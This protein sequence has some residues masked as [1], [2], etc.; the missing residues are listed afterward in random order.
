MIHPTRTNLLLLK[1]KSRSVT[2]STGILKARRQ[3]LIRELLNATVPFLKSREEIRRL[4]G[5][6]LDELAISLGREGRG[7][8]DS[9]AVTTER[10]FTVDIIERRIWGLNYRDV[11]SA[12]SPVRNPQERGYDYS[13]T[14]LHLEECIYLFEKLVESMIG[15]AAFESKIKVIS[16]EIKKSTRRIRILEEKVLPEIKH[17]I[18]AISQYIS[19]RER[20]AHYRL[21]KFKEIVSE[22]EQKHTE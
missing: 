3:A 21:A 4:Y 20:E 1:D 13:L 15:I 2:K 8:I 10:E 14:T 11:Q 22:P 18:R 9:I 16:D 6:A 19:E 17:Q 7:N 5:R 12:E